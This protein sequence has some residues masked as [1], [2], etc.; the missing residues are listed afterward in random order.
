V[1]ERRKELDMLAAVFA[2][3]REEVEAEF[4]A[5]FY[6]Y[7]SAYFR[8]P[9]KLTRKTREMETLIRR[10]GIDRGLL[11]DVGCGF[12]LEAI[13]LSLLVKPEVNIL[14]IDHN[15]EKI[16]L[17][18]KF[19]QK[20]GAR[21]IEFRLEKG[22]GREGLLEADALLCR[23]MVSHVN[24][25]NLFLDAMVAQVKPGG[26][27]YIIDDRNKLSPLTVW[28]TRK[29]QEQ[30]ER[31]KVEVHRLR[32]NDSG[33][34][35]FETRKDMIRRALDLDE[36][37]LDL[38]AGKTAGLYGDAVVAFA[39]ALR[40]GERPRPPAFKYVNPV[41]GE[42]YERP[43]NPFYIKK[44]LRARGLKAR[45]DRPFMGF[46]WRDRGV[47]KWLGLAIEKLHP[48]SLFF[49]PIYHVKGIR[50]PES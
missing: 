35:F 27:I 1:P 49:A 32:A 31:G 22:E 41:T 26:C 11:V 9:S 13:V 6:T 40:E 17:A 18:R 21:R 5:Y 4:S 37:T 42:C 16:L 46:S 2:M 3:G 39:R 28:I 30:A 23:H 43:F 29:Y 12:G 44:L 36:K 14:G 19:A 15:E 20:A 7:F 10:L 45:V 8:D 48:L 50:R 24:D 47:K 38:Y 25:V 34:N 33:L